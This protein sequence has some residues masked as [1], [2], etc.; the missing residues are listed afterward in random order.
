MPAYALYTPGQSEPVMLPE[1]LT[2]GIVIDAL[3]KLPAA[4]SLMVLPKSKVRPRQGGPSLVVIVVVIVV[5]V[6]P[7][8]VFL[9][10]V[11]VPVVQVHVLAVGFGL[12]LR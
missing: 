2:P 6:T 4:P 9:L 5:L 11:L 10:L 8:P 7:V 1:V 3:A 12:P